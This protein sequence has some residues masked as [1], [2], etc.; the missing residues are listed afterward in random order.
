MTWTEEVLDQMLDELKRA[1]VPHA[2]LSGPNVFG[3]FMVERTGTDEALTFR[4]DAL[5]FGR[6]HLL[7]FAWNVWLRRS[8]PRRLTGRPRW[9]ELDG[10]READLAGLVARIVA[11]LKEER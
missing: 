3:S 7:P 11:F 8:R 4:L 10:G 6:T 1:H 9:D 2:L 5:D